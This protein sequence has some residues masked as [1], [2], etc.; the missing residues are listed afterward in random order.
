MRRYVAWWDVEHGGL[1][2]ALDSRTD[3]ELRAK[4]T[5]PA[6]RRISLWYQ[7]LETKVTLV[8]MRVLEQA[9]MVPR[10]LCHDGLIAHD[11]VRSDDDV[12]ALFPACVEAVERE[13]GYVIALELK[14]CLLYTSPSPRD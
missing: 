14:S 3:D 8:A 6:F 11:H 7:D 5:N 1:V 12:R 2:R 13:L 9:G 4:G 10:V